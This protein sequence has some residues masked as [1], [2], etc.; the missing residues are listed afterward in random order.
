LLTH[1]SHKVVKTYRVDIDKKLSRNELQRLRQ[2]VE[3][4]GGLTQSAGVFVKSY[5]DAGMTLK[6]EIHEG[7]KRQIR[8]MMEACGAKVVSLKRLQFGPLHLNDLPVGRWRELTAAEL[9]ALHRAVEEPH[10]GKP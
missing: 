5:S 10:R 1:P 2:G 7:R 8:L 4:E 9:H 3:I 6:I